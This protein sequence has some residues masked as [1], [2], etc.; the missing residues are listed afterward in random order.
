M[1]LSKLFNNYYLDNIRGFKLVF[2]KMGLDKL[3]RNE[4]KVSSSA[5]KHY[6][7]HQD[8]FL[9]YICHIYSVLSLKF[10]LN[11]YDYYYT[12]ILK[13]INIE[14][15][16][17]FDELGRINLTDSRLDINFNKI[18]YNFTSYLLHVSGGGIFRG[19]ESDN[20]I[21]L[22]IAFNLL[23]NRTIKNINNTTL[24]TATVF[25]IATFFKIKSFNKYKNV[26]SDFFY[27]MYASKSMLFSYNAVTHNLNKFIG[28][29]SEFRVN[30]SGSS[31]TKNLNLNTTDLLCI[32][33]LRKAKIF[34]KGRYSRNRSNT[35]L[36][37]L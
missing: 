22:P 7:L 14:D 30:F 25:G 8:V 13:F 21:E 19:I 4:V 36:P 29:S 17:K 16:E 2:D 10:F 34:N 9:K 35:K 27:E 26:Y 31:V 32:Y 11:R 23:S 20:S 15:T 3:F 28:N 5:D 24:N 12:F 37:K 1:I 33:F 18:K 6:Y